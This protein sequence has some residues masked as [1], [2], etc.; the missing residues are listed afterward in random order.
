MIPFCSVAAR[1]KPVRINVDKVISILKDYND[2]V[3]T[4]SKT[5]PPIL[6]VS[7]VQEADVEQAT[8]NV[9]YPPL[10]SVSSE[11]CFEFWIRQQGLAARGPRREFP[12][13]L[14]TRIWI[15]PW[16]KVQVR[17]LMERG[18][19]DMNYIRSINYPHEFKDIYD[20]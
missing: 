7:R 17:V 9:F 20:R 19:F 13:S 12:N 4:G 10:L 16:E 2:L 3:G 1:Q 15:E 8:Y 14:V 5:K 11:V 6:F 18:D